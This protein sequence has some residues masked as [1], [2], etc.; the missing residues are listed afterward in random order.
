MQRENTRDY[1][2]NRRQVHKRA[3]RVV[4]LT[5]SFSGYFISKNEIVFL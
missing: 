1:K 5:L 4:Y 3:D 2:H